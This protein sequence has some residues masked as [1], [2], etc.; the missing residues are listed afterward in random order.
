MC[1]AI[2]QGFMNGN[3]SLEEVLKST[4][5]FMGKELTYSEICN[6]TKAYKKRA[7]EKELS[8]QLKEKTNE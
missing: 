5:K 4:I 3:A 8:Q 2:A 7:K 1:T 6:I